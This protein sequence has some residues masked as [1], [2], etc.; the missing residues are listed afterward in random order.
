[1]D[2]N[3][4]P[5]TF[6]DASIVMRDTLLPISDWHKLVCK[7]SDLMRE[8]NFA[9]QTAEEVGRDWTYAHA[10]EYRARFND[11]PIEEAQEE[12]QLRVDRFYTV[13]AAL[14]NFFKVAA[15]EGMFNEGMLWDLESAKAS[16]LGAKIYQE[17]IA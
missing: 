7:R 10:D 8:M 6:I 15:E 3:D 2:F 12:M 11:E 1:M 16:Y 9:E 14:H 13:Y 5:Q 17:E 4:L